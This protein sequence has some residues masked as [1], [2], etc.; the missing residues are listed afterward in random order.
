MKTLPTFKYSIN[1][2]L[3]LVYYILKIINYFRYQIYNVTVQV[4]EEVLYF[5][6]HSLY[7]QKPTQARS[8]GPRDFECWT[9]CFAACQSPKERVRH[10]RGAAAKRM[11]VRVGARVGG[12]G[13]ELRRLE[14]RDRRGAERERNNTGTKQAWSCWNVK[15]QINVSQQTNEKD[16]AEWRV[17]SWAESGEREDEEE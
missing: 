4:K 6:S 12:R 11:G 13:A 1:F 16:E 9:N 14:D 15:E 17:E 8:H 2:F 3:L 10:R 5:S 7:I